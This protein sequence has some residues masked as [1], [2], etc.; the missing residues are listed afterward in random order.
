MTSNRPPYRVAI[1]GTGGIAAAHAQAL[2]ELPELATLAAVVDLDQPRAEAFAAVHGGTVHA[3]TDAMLAAEQPDLVHICTPPQTHAP[4]AL[5]VVRSGTAVLVEKPTAL[6]L[7]EMDELT[8]AQEEHGVPVLTVFQ[9]RFGA[10]VLRLR[11]MLAEGV[12]GRPLVATCNTLWY[13]GD[14][15]FA[16][17]WRGRWEVEGG[18]PTMGHGIHQF[19]L[20]LSILGPW[21]E[22][23]AFAAR[24]TRPTDTEDVSIALARFENGALATIV[25]SVVSPR[26]T[27]T[28][29][30][31]FEHASVEVEHLYGYRDADWRFT[32]AP[33]QEELA[34]SWNES[35]SDAISSHRLQ[36]EAIFDAFTAGTEPGVSLTE[37]R[38]T[39]EF[40]AA[41]YASAFR[42][43]PI[44]AGSL[45]GEDPFTRSMD[46]GVVPWPPLKDR[47]P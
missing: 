4:L 18:G 34:V 27:T 35:P 30:F 47:T 31:D 43:V 14:D 5:Q 28:L 13:R 16:V 37:A 40:A 19:D 38:R 10:A 26:E 25:N 8:R 39:L 45:T 2:A 6:S 12:L 9:H 36:F 17:P 15:Y 23:S 32:P 21:T 33:G 22:V 42:G 29:R 46:G 7:Q 11:R 20:L 44:A 3:R 41:T 1:I 24:Q